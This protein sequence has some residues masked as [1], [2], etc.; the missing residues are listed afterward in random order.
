MK[1]ALLRAFAAH[2]ARGS[3]DNQKPRRKGTR[4]AGHKLELT[5][6][7]ERSRAERSST[8]R[9]LCGW[10]ESHH[11]QAGVRQEYANHLRD[12]AKAEGA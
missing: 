6:S 12:V 3:D 4:V 9:C 1:T 10:E 5:P 11:S 2:D 7:A 8:G